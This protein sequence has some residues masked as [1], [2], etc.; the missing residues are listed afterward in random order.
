MLMGR[1]AGKLHF[2]ISNYFVPS[3]NPFI[4]ML[5]VNQGGTMLDPSYAAISTTNH[6][7]LGAVVDILVGMTIEK[8]D[9][10]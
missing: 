10:G 5:M 4:Y 3:A 8:F 6:L 9:I 7:K 1:K 2:Y